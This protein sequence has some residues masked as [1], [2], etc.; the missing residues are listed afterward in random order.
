MQRPCHFL[1]LVPVLLWY[2]KAT[3]NQFT[4]TPLFLASVVDVPCA[5]C[6]EISVSEGEGV[7]KGGNVNF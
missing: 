4:S 1:T 3:E 2:V 7:E 6:F 5:F